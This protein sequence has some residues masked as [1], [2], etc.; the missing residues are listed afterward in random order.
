VKY[1]KGNIF[2]N[3]LRGV[4]VHQVNCQGV[5]GSGIAKEIRERWPVVFQSYHSKCKDPKC[6][7]S[8]RGANLLGQTQWV[9]VEQD[10]WIVNLFG[11]QFYGR[12]GR[13][14]TSY[15]AL[16]EGFKSIARD[17]SD[18]GFGP[19][20]VHH[21]YIGCGLGG[22]VWPVVEAIIDYHMSGQSTLWTVD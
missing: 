3:V 14:Y 4:I 22:G 19:E 17:L 2:D 6:Y 13:R 18:R 15:D 9:A 7:G 21:P 5:M 20:D 16:D 12:D 1:A 8:N 10:L 11:Q